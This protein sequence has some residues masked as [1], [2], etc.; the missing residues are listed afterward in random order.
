MALYANYFHSWPSTMPIFWLP[1]NF[2]SA[3]QGTYTC[4]KLKLRLFCILL[5]SIKWRKK[6]NDQKSSFFIS[7]I[8]LEDAAYWSLSE[9]N[10]LSML[11]I[12]ALLLSRVF[13]TAQDMN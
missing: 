9:V 3:N 10:K 6:Q 7:I 1:I 11:V 8:A 2:Y 4:S 5:V 13:Y 12:G